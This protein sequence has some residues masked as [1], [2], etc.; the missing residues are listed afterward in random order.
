MRQVSRRKDQLF[1]SVLGIGLSTLDVGVG[2]SKRSSIGCD[3]V[4]RLARILQER[5]SHPSAKRPGERTEYKFSQGI[6]GRDLVETV[7]VGRKYIN[8][9]KPAT[10][11]TFLT[12]SS[13][14]VTKF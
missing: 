7:S 3:D 12:G 10:R 8:R 2:E 11:H 6:Q 9:C 13:E 4:G 1:R 14:Q 5:L